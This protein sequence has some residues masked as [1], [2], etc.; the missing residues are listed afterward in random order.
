MELVDL[1]I[2]ALGIG[3]VCT[4]GIEGLADGL[5]PYLNTFALA[6]LLLFFTLVALMF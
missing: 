1:L 2:T 4:Y 3:V 6:C 5:E